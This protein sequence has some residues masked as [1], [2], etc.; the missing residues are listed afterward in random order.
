[1]KPEKQYKSNARI[2]GESLRELLPYTNLGWQLVASV[3]LFFG[4]GYGLD[5]LLDTGD[6][7][8]IIL[9]VLG[10]VYGL[11]SVIKSA[12]DLQNRKKTEKK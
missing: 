4:I 2:I 5:A 11:W 1:M 12:N 10:I 6:L 7:L 3:L 9:S 8:T